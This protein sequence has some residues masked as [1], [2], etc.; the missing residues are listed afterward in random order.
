MIGPE[1]S[2]I[3]R[4]VCP[5][6]KEGPIYVVT[7][8]GYSVAERADTFH[9]RRVKPLP[10]SLA[11]PLQQSGLEI[12][13]LEGISSP[14]DGLMR[15][16]A[17]MSSKAVGTWAA[18]DAKVDFNAYQFRPLLKYLRSP[19]RRILVADE[20]GLGKT[21]ESAYILVEEL[22]SE[23]SARV[24]VL[25][26]GGLRLK[27]RDEL[28]RR[29]G[30][31]FEITSGRRLKELLFTKGGFRAIVS[32]DSNWEGTAAEAR[33]PPSIDLVVID[34]VH[35]LIGRGG[36]TQRRTM[37]FQISAIAK[38]AVGLSATPV[39]LEMDDLRRVLEVIFGRE[40]KKAEFD[41][42]AS[43]A[44]LVNTTIRDVLAGR[45]L[46]ISVTERLI[47][48]AEGA[49]DGEV[50]SLLESYGTESSHNLRAGLAQ[51]LALL[52][53]FEAIMTRARRSDVGES[54]TRVVTN[55]SVALN[56]RPR[57]RTGNR[58]KNRVSESSLYHEVDSL[59]Q[60][61]FSHVHRMQ[62]SSCLP[63]TVELLNG[64]M[65]GFDVWQHGDEI[66]SPLSVKERDDAEGFHVV[67]G[68]LPPGAREKCSEL[69]AKFG[70]L[71][72][73]SKLEKLRSILLQLREPRSDG[74]PHKA[75]VFTQWRHTWGYLTRRLGDL[76]GMRAFALSGDDSDFKVEET[77]SAFKSWEG[78]AVLIST[79]FLSEGLDIQAADTLANY[80]FPYNPQ[81]VEQRIGRI[82][83]IGQASK[84]VSIHNLVVEGSLDEHILGT[85]YTRLE[86]FAR[87]IG[88]SPAVLESAATGTG[89][90]EARIVE[91]RRAA[92]EKELV[93]VGP[94]AGVED[95]LDEQTRTL[96]A[97][98]SGDLGRLSWL[99]VLRLLS[100]FSG[101]RAKVALEDEGGVVIGP[102]ADDDVIAIKDATGHGLE[103]RVRAQLLSYRDK[104]L[105]IT[106]AKHAARE[107][108]FATP[109]SPL[110]KLA[111]VV[112]LN[113][114]NDP[115]DSG[116][117]L[118]FEWNG[119]TSGVTICRYSC[120][121]R[122]GTEANITYWSD[123]HGRAEKLT[124]TLLAETVSSL[125]TAPLRFAPSILLPRHVSTE[126]EADFERW[127]KTRKGGHDDTEESAGPHASL[128]YIATI[129][130]SA[131][132]RSGS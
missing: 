43:S 60:S 58:G 91:E 77:L 110:V 52:N 95:L 104:E 72:T 132:E 63:A 80:D 109:L 75:I 20:V 124:G 46:G 22:T 61:H 106:L 69:V 48:L 4:L 112:T 18:F 98:R 6:G 36:D 12:C 97:Q 57:S 105:M 45:P 127:V 32:Y 29:F 26:P 76:D 108:L 90:A 39:H 83:R 103:E 19:S 9:L 53:P 34:E 15:I 101:G 115:P 59:L 49:N 44:A 70:L 62:L 3:G 23:P 107:G 121:G 7:G 41:R 79:D 117:P 66:E 5:K 81:R 116:K 125:E 128:E 35:N 131:A 67:R 54:R 55:H 73:D 8:T 65:E 102:V 11:Q 13:A 30:L 129:R 56:R 111:S 118:G 68:S 1:D 113:S 42:D 71:R 86:I 93:E 92:T 28:W 16:V 50:G 126:V 78:P 130:P 38:A 100:V 85:L 47:S 64:G 27:W 114:F 31:Y 17:R 33:T 24:L 89:E 96:R 10:P 14:R 99:P 88:D 2:K 84:E 94:L 122:L 40:V 74:R 82:D 51:R 119:M 120:R 123:S 87:A 25:C 37:A 21:I